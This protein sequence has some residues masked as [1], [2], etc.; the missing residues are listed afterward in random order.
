MS[1]AKSENRT[2]EKATAVAGINKRN[3]GIGPQ[4]AILQECNQQRPVTPRISIAALQCVVNL[5]AARASNTVTSSCDYLF[6]KLGGPLRPKL[7]IEVRSLNWW[8]EQNRLP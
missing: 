4:K 8:W 7:R 3:S 5:E 1:S 2:Y 6:L